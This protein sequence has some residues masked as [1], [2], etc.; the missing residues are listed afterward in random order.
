MAVEQTR[1][2]VPVVNSINSVIGNQTLSQNL[3]LGALLTTTQ[4]VGQ[5]LEK[6]GWDVFTDVLGKVGIKA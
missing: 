6:A 5:H 4:M 2:D 1:L 3:A